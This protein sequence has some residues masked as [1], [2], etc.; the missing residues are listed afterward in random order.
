MANEKQK[1]IEKRPK[2]EESSHEEEE[3]EEESSSIDENY[4]EELEEEESSGVV[5]V[6]GYGVA[7]DED[8]LITSLNKLVQKPK[9]ALFSRKRVREDP[10]IQKQAV[11]KEKK[12]KNKKNKKQDVKQ[13]QEVEK[14]EEAEGVWEEIEIFDDES[15]ARE[16]MSKYDVGE[17]EELKVEKKV[18]D[19]PGPYKTFETEEEKQHWIEAAIE[20]LQGIFNYGSNTEEEEHLTVYHHGGKVFLFSHYEEFFTSDLDY[21]T[22]IFSELLDAARS[23]TL[24]IV[25]N[26]INL[27]CEGPELFVASVLD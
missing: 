1:R 10:E 6:I 9:Y 3:E 27:A 21:T 26:K 14:V 19:V 25:K 24:A 7:Y 15:D 11:S 5:T 13:Q 4:V 17:L 20:T 22:I 12:N 2:D 16:V 23:E 8:E 18:L